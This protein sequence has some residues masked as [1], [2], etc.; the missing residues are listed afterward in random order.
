ML[1]LKSFNV[2]DKFSTDYRKGLVYSVVYI[3]ETIKL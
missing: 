2:L 1:G 3:Q